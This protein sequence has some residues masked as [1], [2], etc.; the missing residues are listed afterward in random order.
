MKKAARLARSC[1]RIMKSHLRFNICELPSSLLLD[2]EVPD[3]NHR[4]QAKFV[5][6]C[7]HW[8]QHLIRTSSDGRTEICDLLQLNV[9]LNEPPGFTSSLYPDAST[10]LRM[11]L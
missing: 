7:L 4:T 6:Y 8:T 1:F 10:S 9:R 2:P 5:V 3:L 11:Y